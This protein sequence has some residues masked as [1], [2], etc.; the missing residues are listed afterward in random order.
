MRH[1]AAPLTRR[2][3][4]RTTGLVP[5]ALAIG[6]LSLVG[7]GITGNTI[8][9]FV[10]DANTVANG[11]AA[12]LPGLTT[13]TGM[14]AATI[15]KVQGYITEAQNLAAE[16]AS[17]AT[18]GGTSL[19]AT[20]SNFAGVVGNA[21]SSLTGIPG[22]SKAISAA[23]SLLPVILSAAGIVLA[24]PPPQMP[25]AQARAILLAAAGR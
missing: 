8:P 23:S 14:T 4:L 7:C 11:L 15:T 3:L 20:V 22:L 17:A 6:G 2:A 10:T 24:G 5:A 1:L 25:A 16:L 18:A 21:V 9:Q 13:V 12:I 19:V